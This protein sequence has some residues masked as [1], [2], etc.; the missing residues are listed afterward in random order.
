M[1]ASAISI[2]SANGPACRKTSVRSSPSCPTPCTVVTLVNLNASQARTGSRARQRH[3]E[4][5]LVSM[6]T[7]GKTVPINSPLLTVRLEP[8]C[9][10]TLVLEMKRYTNPPTAMHPWHRRGAR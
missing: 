4:H 8:G 5:Q 1:P 10:Q 7:G 9:G 6:T 3:G 2:P